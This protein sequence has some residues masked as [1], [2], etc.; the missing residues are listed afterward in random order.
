MERPPLYAMLESDTAMDYD[1]TDI[2][3][4][5]D[6]GRDHG[7]AVIHQWMDLVASHVDGET[8][9]NVLDLGCGTGRFSQA[10]AARF[11]ANVIGIDPSTKMLH[12]AQSKLSD[13]HVFYVEGFAEAVPLVSNSV[14]M[15]FISMVFHHFEDRQL[16][17]RECRRVLRDGGR[18]C[19]RTGTSEKSSMYP[20]VPFFPES[21]SLL[22]QRLPSLASQREAF[23]AASFCTA[24]SEVVVQ[25]VAPNYGVYAQKLSLG[26]DS[27]LMSLDPDDFKAG[28]DSLRFYAAGRGADEAVIEP[29]DFLVFDVPE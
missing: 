6:R 15:I 4:R 11:S 8:V 24:S 25:Q 10:L 3:E 14:D 18:L 13:S 21:R 26:A 20:Y 27:I 9:Q 23:E 16:A 17:A 19:L 12:Q 5:Y 28:M 1:Q 29:I 2:P 7:P 22:E